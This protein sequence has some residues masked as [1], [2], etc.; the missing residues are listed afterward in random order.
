MLLIALYS[1]RS[2][3]ML[4]EQISSNALFCWFLD[5]GPGDEAS[6]RARSHTIVG[7]CSTTASLRKFFRRVVERAQSAG[8]MSARHF[9]VD[10]TLIEA[11][12]SMKSFRPKDDACGDGNAW[13]DFSR[14][15]AK[16]SDAWI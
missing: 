1:I 13:A 4:C 5:M 12:A 6:I 15:R 10:G 14:S 16:Q 2:E 9:S 3:R 7:A 11:W 8:L